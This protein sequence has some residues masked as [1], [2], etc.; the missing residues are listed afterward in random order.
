MYLYILISAQV[1]YNV[2]SF[3]YDEEI[4]FETKFHFLTIL[5]SKLWHLYS[6]DLWLMRV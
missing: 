5:K 4:D 1:Y 3:L 6:Y 2:G